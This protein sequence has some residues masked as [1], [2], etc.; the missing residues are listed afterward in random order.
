MTNLSVNIG[1]IRDLRSRPRHS[2]DS[3]TRDLR[4]N[5]RDTTLWPAEYAF[6]H[7]KLNW[8]LPVRE[9]ERGRTTLRASSPA[10]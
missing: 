3:Y 7:R 2:D 4:S 6:G 10:G 1:G 5:F 9:L 8:Q